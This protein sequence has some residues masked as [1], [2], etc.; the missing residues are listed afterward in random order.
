MRNLKILFA[1]VLSFASLASLAEPT[2]YIRSNGQFVSR[3]TE[4]PRSFWVPAVRGAGEAFQSNYEALQEYELHVRDAKWFAGLNWG[5]L[6]AL[7]LYSAISSS[8]DSFNGLAGALIFFV[9]WTAG[10]VM[11]AKS[12]QHLLRAVN[13]MNGIPPAQA[14]GPSAL[15]VP[16]LAWTF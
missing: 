7:V 14:R 4:Y 12:N 13:L 1:F 11:L 8:T 10:A 6:G 3:G 15:R 16:L 2:V 9:P 5:A